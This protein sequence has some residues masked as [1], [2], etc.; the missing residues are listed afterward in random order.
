MSDD[1]AARISGIGIGPGDPELVTLKAF[2][3]MKEAD[4][5]F[6]PKARIKGE[7]LARNIVERA[8]IK[9]GIFIELEFPMITDQTALEQKW[10]AAAA[11]VIEKISEIASNSAKAV[12]ITL[13]DPG[14]YS[15]WTYLQNA[16]AEIAPEINTETVPGISTMNAAAAALNSPLITGRERLA[17]IPLPK[18]LDELDTLTAIFDTIVVYKI[19]SRL[20]DF[21]SKIE[22][23]G[24]S[25]TTSLVRRAGL[26]DEEIFSRLS[27]VKPETDGYLSTAVIHCKT[28]QKDH[29]K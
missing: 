27:E 9:G 13:G 21:G 28:T 2:R 10:L 14:I 25:G 7:S 26:P 1:T 11:A 3:L 5:I 4:L 16:L 6:T 20:A 29:E 12:F 15:T 24:L 23:L 22:Q 18:E 19:S 17:L 8:G